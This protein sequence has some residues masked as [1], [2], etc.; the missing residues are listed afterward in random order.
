MRKY[1]EKVLK[2][3]IFQRKSSIMDTTTK[4]GE[5]WDIYL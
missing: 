1:E 3:L 2:L 5:K 4:G